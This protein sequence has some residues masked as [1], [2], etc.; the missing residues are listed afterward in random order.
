MDRHKQKTD[1]NVPT[2]ML[3]RKGTLTSPPHPKWFRIAKIWFIILL[4][5]I[6]SGTIA[7]LVWEVNAH[8][9]HKHHDNHKH[10]EKHVHP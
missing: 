7:L 3:K 4:W 8:K 1:N 9:E 6:V 5:L 2:K 10:K